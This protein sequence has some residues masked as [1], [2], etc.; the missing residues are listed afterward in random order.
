[1]NWLG[2][3][4]WVW[5]LGIG[6]FCLILILAILIKLAEARQIQRNRRFFIDQLT[7]TYERIQD[8]PSP[9]RSSQPKSESRPPTADE[10]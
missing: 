9:D 4:D 3:V 10:P 2:E 5:L 6:V 8:R 1:M 7:D